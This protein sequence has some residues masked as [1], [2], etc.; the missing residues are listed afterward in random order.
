MCWVGLVAAVLVLGLGAVEPPVRARAQPAAQRTDVR[1]FVPFY[2]G[3]LAAGLTV[4]ARVPGSCFASSI[5]SQGRPDAWRCMT[6]NLILDPCYDGTAQGQSALACPVSPWSSQVRVLTLT[7]TLPREQANHGALLASPPWA[8]QLVDGSRCVYL[9][10]ATMGIAGMR[11]NYGC[12]NH[13]GVIGDVDRSEPLW[14]V[15]VQPVSGWTVR[16][17]GVAV[18]WY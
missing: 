1:L 12:E 15:F 10:G 14:R 8:V 2:Q 5:A 6:G 3:K 11:L 7:G 13:S 4:V 18:A 9:T 17:I 16:Q